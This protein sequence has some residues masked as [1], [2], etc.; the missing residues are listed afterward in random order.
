MRNDNQD[1]DADIMNKYSEISKRNRSTGFTVI[2][3]VVFVLAVVAIAALGISLYVFATR[4]E[5]VRGFWAVAPPT[6][7]SSGGQFTYSVQKKTGGQWQPLSGRQLTFRIA[8]DAHLTLTPPSGATAPGG[9]L[10]VTITPVQDYCYG[11]NLWVTDVKSG[12]ED[13][14]IH[15]TVT[16][17]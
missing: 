4:E 3:L 10:V 2:E 5:P 1:G 17:P 8:P 15:F 9:D 14:P 6:I 12:Q 13:P 7:P 16:C 11:G